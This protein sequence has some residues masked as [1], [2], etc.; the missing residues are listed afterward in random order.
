[1]TTLIF[2]SFMLCCMGYLS[3]KCFKKLNPF[4]I[5]IG[6]FIAAYWWAIISKEEYKIVYCSAFV[7]G[8]IYAYRNPF[9][10]FK[11]GLA[12][13]RMSFRL[14]KAKSA[15]K[16]QFKNDYRHAEDSIR[17]QS[18]N[19][20]RQKTQAEDDLKRQQQEVEAEL[21]NQKR[22]AEDNIKNQQQEAEAELQRAAERLRREQ[23]AF[24]RE[25]ANAQ[26]NKQ[27]A[28]ADKGLNPKNFSDACQILGVH[29]GASLAEFKKAYRHLSNMFHPDKFAHFD[30]ILKTQAAEN[31]KMINAAWDTIK[32]KLK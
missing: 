15:S 26:N 29:S 19:L 10:W 12:D 16:T 20:Y 21:R 3:G 6:L 27:E 25:Q 30:G 13:M 4:L 11:D 14:A 5:L 7:V 8:F 23:E 32:R 24:R 22:Q 31:S 9:L 17:S 18:E 1:M 28:P 2:V